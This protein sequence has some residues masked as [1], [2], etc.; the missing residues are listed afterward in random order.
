MTAI[1]TMIEVKNLTKRYGNVRALDAVSFEVPR[2]Q[3]LGFLGPNGAGKTT[4]MKILTC[5]IAPTS[6]EVRV[7]GLDIS[8]D[9]LGIRR[10]LGYL[11][12]TAPLYVDMRVREYLDFVADVRGIAVDAKDKAL[13]RVVEVCGLGDVRDKEIRTLS[14]GF[15]QRVGLAQAMIHDPSILILDEPTSGLD[16]NQIAEIRELVK[17][18]GR[19]RTVILSTHNLTEVQATA[20]R[21]IIIHQGKLVADGSPE[22]LESSRGGARYDVVLA[23]PGGGV[24]AVKEAFGRVEG[25]RGVDAAESGR[26]G[27]VDV[28]VHGD[29]REDLRAQIFKA[30]VDKGLVL[31][32]LGRKQVDLES[33][34]RRLTTADGAAGKEAH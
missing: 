9:P 27:E 17:S 2:G 32:G 21:V 24:A 20:G 4:T 6:G 34:F 28:T 18:L 15:R 12:E 19:E 22:E 23:A 5:F 11:Q 29:A 1:E 13:A 3:V 10:R 33:I 25:V 26:G 16:P 14:K 30:A 7:A 31:L 8:E